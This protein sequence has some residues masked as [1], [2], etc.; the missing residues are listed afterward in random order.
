MPYVFTFLIGLLIGALCVF[1]ALLENYRRL[2]KEKRDMQSDRKDLDAATGKMLAK[3]KEL[4]FD[5]KSL[6]G[7]QSEFEAR[8]IKYNELLDE[9]IMLKRDFQNIDVD[10]R[11]L[12]LDRELQR[13]TQEQLDSRC[14][15]LGSRYMK[16]NIKWISNSLNANNYATCKDR[17]LTVI[18]R[19][20]GIG[21][22]VS[23]KEESDLL[24]DLRS[25]YEKTVR[26]AF[27]RE[28][29]A[30]IKA[31]IRE[32]QRLEREIEKELQQLERER[33]A[34]HAALEKALKDAEGKHSEEIDKLKARLTEAEEKS[35]RAKSRAQMTKSGHVYIISNIGSFGEDVYKI[36]MTR[37]LEPS[38]RVRELS[39]ASVPFP[40]DIHM[41]IACD[42][43]PALENSLHRALHMSRINKSNPRK[44]FFQAD[45]ESIRK[46]VEEHHGEVQYQIDPEAL[47]Y[48]QTLAMSDEDSEFI[49]SVFDS[50]DE[51]DESNLDTEL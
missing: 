40:F 13:E 30:R 16:E 6:S 36:G 19:C 29:Q 23:D 10:L 32:E 38:D 39:S 48:R 14:G 8:A 42:N 47:E 51:K 12:H 21:L 1:L 17:L 24:T 27:E 44:E 46:L 4:E 43:A 26:L 25:N 20:R 50:L 22:E 11:K 31:Q 9:N 41:M 49:E 34:I 3:Q 15:E 28:E 7:K 2:K 37:R 35:K 33:A 45:I 18:K 5:I